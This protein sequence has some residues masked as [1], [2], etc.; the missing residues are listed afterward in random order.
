MVDKQVVKILK[1]LSQKSKICAAID[2]AFA[3]SRIT[4]I[5]NISL[6]LSTDLTKGKALSR[7][8]RVHVYFQTQENKWVIIHMSRTLHVSPHLLQFF[9]QIFINLVF[10]VKQIPSAAVTSKMGSSFSWQISC[11]SFLLGLMIVH[12][13]RTK[14]DKTWWCP[15]FMLFTKLNTPYA[16]GCL[17]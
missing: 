8:F 11:L 4:H 1:L 13:I 7:Q 5:Y 6:N 14:T 16:Q 3:K 17:A 15:S 9:E 10:V 12:W 2:V